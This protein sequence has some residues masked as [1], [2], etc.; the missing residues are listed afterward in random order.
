VNSARCVEARSV[1]SSNAA[2]TST[3]AAADGVGAGQSWNDGMGPLGEL[4]FPGDIHRCWSVVEG[5][6]NK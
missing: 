1:R 5:R 4:V 6:S 2:V 3:S